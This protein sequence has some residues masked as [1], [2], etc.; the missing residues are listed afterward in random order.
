MKEAFMVKKWNKTWN[1]WVYQN[2]DTNE[3]NTVLGEGQPYNTYVE[4][5]EIIRNAGSGVYAIDKIFIKNI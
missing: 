1:S 4:A 3:F 2:V 5:Q